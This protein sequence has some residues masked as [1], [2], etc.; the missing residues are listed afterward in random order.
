MKTIEIVTHCY[1]EQH[2]VFA[3]LLTAQLSSL[4]LWP[5]E[6]QRAHDGVHCG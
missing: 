3:K 4:L 5:P 6:M 1:A 2:P